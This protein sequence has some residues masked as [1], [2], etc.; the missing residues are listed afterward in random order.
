VRLQQMDTASLPDRLADAPDWARIETV[1]LDM[2]GTL[3]DLRFDNYFW[4]EVVPQRYGA[5]HGIPP[6]TALERLLPRI[7]AWRGTL[8]WYCVDHWTEELGLDI[9]ALKVEM[10]EHIRFLPGAEQFLDRLGGLGKRRLLTTNA[11]PKS[12]AVKHGQTG[13]GRHFDVLVSSH[14][15]GAPK[16]SADF[17]A[18][19]ASRHEIEPATTLFVDDSPSVLSAAR[20]AGVRWIYQV[21]QPDS[22][23]PPRTPVP[24]IPG[25]RHLSEL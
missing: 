24:G 7:D 21:L 3:L 13:I 23:Q 11:H 17:W 22:T 4:F 18:R 9:E 12:L 20:D 5:L 8:E 1:C 16:E 2:D 19:L 10:R 15:I 6:A 25:V 14:L